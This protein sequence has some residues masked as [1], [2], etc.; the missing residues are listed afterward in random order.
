MT[1]GT[2]PARRQG[3]GIPPTVLL[4]ACLAFPDSGRATDAYFP[5]FTTFSPNRQFRL[6]VKSPDNVGAKGGRPFAKSFVFQMYHGNTQ[7]RIWETRDLTRHPIKARIRDDGWLVIHSHWSGLTF[8]NPKGQRAGVQ[9]VVHGYLPPTDV[10]TY[11]AMTTGGPMWEGY[12]H[13]FFATVDD[14]TYYCLRTW[15]MR[16]VVFDLMNGEQIADEGDV[17]KAVDIAEQT[18]VLTTLGD[19]AKL[20]RATAVIEHD[21]VGHSD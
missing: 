14:R 12:S 15:W 5:D 7:E 6:E 17:K 2:H 13:W 1:R 18:F 4:F 21:E 19:A 9:G 20:V 3:S 16:R 10:D 8:V 11:V